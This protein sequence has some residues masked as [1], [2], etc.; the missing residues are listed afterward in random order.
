MISGISR[1]FTVLAALVP[2]RTTTVRT[3]LPRTDA[4]LQDLNRIERRLDRRSHGPLLDVGAG[5]FIAFAEFVD[6]PFGAALGVLRPAEICR[7]R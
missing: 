1:L 3:W 4:A 5:Y 6:E 7:L 2:R